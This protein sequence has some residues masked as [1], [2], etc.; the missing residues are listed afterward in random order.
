MDASARR[1]DIVS[2]THG[3]LSEELLAQL[4]GAD[5]IVHAGDMTS[6]MDFEH[7]QQIAPVRAVL[8]NNDYFFDYGAGV[9]RLIRFEYEG[10][11]FTVSHYRRDLPRDCTGIAVFGHSHVPVIEEKRGAVF[12]NPGSP[13]FP[14]SEHGAT[15]A[16]AWLSQGSLL[17]METIKL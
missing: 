11:T 5:L 3:H 1:V 4:E 14:R 12:V 15:M 17:S 7:L 8:G 9:E 6:E 13:T 10:V 2:D 16:R